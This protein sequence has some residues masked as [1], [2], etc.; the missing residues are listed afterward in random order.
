MKQAGYTPKSGYYSG[1]SK[2]EPYF[3]K[4]AYPVLWYNAGRRRVA[5]CCIGGVL[6][7]PNLPGV[8]MA[9]KKI[10]PN[11]EQAETSQVTNLTTTSVDV[12]EAELV[13]LHQSAVQEIT[14][15]E[16]ELHQS[17][18]LDIATAELHAH[19]A[20]LGMVT[21]KEVEITNSGVG[22][23]RADHVNVAGSAG[24]VLAETANL[25]NT[26]AG[27]VAGDQVRSERIESLVLLAR[28][29][30][31]DVQTVVDTRAALIAGMV[32]GLL[33]GIIL[34]IGRLVFGRKS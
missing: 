1:N 15:E 31:G 25:G 5:S 29:V 32:G 16:V 21:A 12:I 13:R 26:Y 30:E 27:V 20:A 24:V 3:I 2:R 19:E 18:A 14:A 6:F 4:N 8:T 9:E 22:I 10:D 34:L 23:I 11:D 33:T 28:H 17:I 7:A